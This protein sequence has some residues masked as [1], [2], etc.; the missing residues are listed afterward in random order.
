[1]DADHLTIRIANDLAAA[2]QVVEAAEAFCAKR[3]VPAK[4]AYH[5]GLAIDEALTN[6]IN[7]GFPEG[8]RGEIT[9]ELERRGKDILVELIDDGSAF[10]P[11]SAPEPDLTS[12]LQERKIGGLGVHM[13]RTFMTEA[14][15]SRDGGRNHLRLR[16]RFGEQ[17]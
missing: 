1:V 8:G 7:Y 4:A 12:P 5:I 17:E 15:Y 6:T 10:D 3:G 9:L 14:A 2:A 13:I 11:L 16:K